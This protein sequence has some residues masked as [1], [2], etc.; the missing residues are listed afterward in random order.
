MDMFESGTE[1][2]A[3]DLLIIDSLFG[4]ACK[5]GSTYEHVVLTRFC[6]GMREAFG[7]DENAESVRHV[8][9]FAREHYDYVSPEELGAINA[10]NAAAGLCSHGLDR[11]CCPAGCGG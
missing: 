1:I 7:D 2:T 6:E 8:F 11:D 9:L 3:S 4:E 10:D 5:Q